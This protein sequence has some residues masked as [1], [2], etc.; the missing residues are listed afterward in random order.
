MNLTLQRFRLP[1]LALTSALALVGCN[2]FE[3]DNNNG[4]KGDSSNSLMKFVER[5]INGNTNEEAAGVN[6]ES[7]AID[8]DNAD[9]AETSLPT[10]QAL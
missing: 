5:E 7:A 6:V 4:N 2:V 10:P 9:D 8:A 3:S 1:L